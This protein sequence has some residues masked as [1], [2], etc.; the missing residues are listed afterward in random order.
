MN[1][2]L[3]ITSIFTIIAIVIANVLAIEY[4]IKRERE[5]QEK[6]LQKSGCPPCPVCNAA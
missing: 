1:R 4:R 6:T 2:A 3:I 5:E